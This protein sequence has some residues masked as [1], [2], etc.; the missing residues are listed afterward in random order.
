MAVG[1]SAIDTIG[2]SVGAVG[3]GAVGLAVSSDRRG[4]AGLASVR[5]H[6]VVGHVLDEDTLA[7]LKQMSKAIRA[8]A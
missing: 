5:R 1:G 7:L 3:G 6:Q 2:V 4:N 8:T